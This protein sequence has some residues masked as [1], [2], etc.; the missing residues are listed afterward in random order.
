MSE[1]ILDIRFFLL[2]IIGEVPIIN[3]LGNIKYREIAQKNRP[4]LEKRRS[5]LTQLR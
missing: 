3:A 5:A 4:P 2:P 1:K